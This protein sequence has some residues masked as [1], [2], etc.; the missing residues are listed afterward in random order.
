MLSSPAEEFNTK[1]SCK[2]YHAFFGSV[3][4]QVKLHFLP[5]VYL[6]VRNGHS[7]LRPLSNN[8]CFELSAEFAQVFG[9]CVQPLAKR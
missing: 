3:K 5:M 6:K 7:L 2:T 4:A 9:Q 1:G 8:D